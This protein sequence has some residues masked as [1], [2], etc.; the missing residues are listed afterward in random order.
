MRVLKGLLATTVLVVS[1]TSALGA[2]WTFVDGSVAVQSKGT[3]VG[4]GRK[5][6]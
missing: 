2:S 6:K 4:G 1:A 5:E 3:G